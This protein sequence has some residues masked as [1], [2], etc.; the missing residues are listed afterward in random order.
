MFLGRKVNNLLEASGIFL[1]GHGIFKFSEVFDRHLLKLP[2]IT[3]F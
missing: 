3:W 1:L 2:F